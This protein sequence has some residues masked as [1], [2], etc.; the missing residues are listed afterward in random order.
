MSLLPCGRSLGRSC[1]LSARINAAGF[2]SQKF[3][4]SHPLDG[5]KF[6]L[7]FVASE[8]LP[9]ANP[10]STT[11]MAHTRPEIWRYLC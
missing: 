4:H 2:L 9:Y 10:I 8:T 1:T 3:F 11:M 5:V 6:G 7:A